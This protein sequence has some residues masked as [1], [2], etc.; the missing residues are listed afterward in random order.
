MYQVHHSIPGYDEH[1]IHT[2][3]SKRDKLQERERKRRKIYKPDANGNAMLTK[4]NGI[5]KDTR[6]ICCTARYDMSANL[7]TK[8]FKLSKKKEE[9]KKPGQT[10]A[11]G[12]PDK[13]SA[14]CSFRSG[15]I[16]SPR[17]TSIDQSN[18]CVMTSER[19]A[20]VRGSELPS[21]QYSQHG[22][23]NVTGA[24]QASDTKTFGR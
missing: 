15:E 18:D 4:K 10:L 12:R 24:G 20:L 8:T 5:S 14:K 22:R 19:G 9:K 17:Q 2:Q 13:S 11:Q 3:A 21:G 7:H 6:Q 1:N 23:L 16:P